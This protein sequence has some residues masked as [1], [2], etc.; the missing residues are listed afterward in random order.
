VIQA[1][2][3][4]PRIMYEL[5]DYEWVSSGR[6]ARTAFW[7]LRSGAPWRDLPESFGTFNSEVGESSVNNSQT[8]EQTSRIAANQVRKSARFCRNSCNFIANDHVTMGSSS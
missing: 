4:Q 6:S 3:L 2:K 1:P 7:V 8:V 5:A